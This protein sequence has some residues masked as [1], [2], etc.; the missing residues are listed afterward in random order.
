MKTQLTH[1][2]YICSMI[3]IQPIV[4]ALVVLLFAGTTQ[5]QITA[6]QLSGYDPKTSINTVTTAVP[7]LMISPD[8]RS[9]ALGDAGGALSPDA[10]SIHWNMSKLA[11]VKKKAGFAVSYTPWLRA[12]VPD[13]NLA[14]LSFYTKLKGDQAISASL[15]YFS[16]GD[17]TFTDIVG[18]TIG[19]FKPNEFALDVGYARKFSDRWSGGLT[20][21][22]IY[23]NLTGG[24]SLYDGQ[25]TKAGQS[26]AADL[27]AY[28]RNDELEVGGK[29]A[30]YST[31][32]VISN[33]GTKISYTESGR[34]DFIP[35][36][37]RWGNQFKINLDDY[38]SLAVLVDFNKLMVPTPP[39]YAVN[40]STG[41]PIKDQN[42]NY[43]IAK[44]K[45]PNRSVV[46]GILTSFAD[47]PGGFKEEIKEIN[48]S[49]GVEYWYDGQFA[50][51]AGYFHEPRTKG[52]R[53]YF[54]LG[55]GLRYSVFGLDFAYLIAT[56]QRNPLENTLR[57]TLHFDF[58][59]FKAQNKDKD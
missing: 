25:G 23:S 50:V 8:A 2:P 33:I 31:G 54:T 47:A 35:T 12:L 38:N 24:I 18:N 9:G 58:D 22:Y 51:R 26:V 36:N 29:D 44:G 41:Q 16:L 10:N 40:D 46:N 37:L 7:F 45:D 30:E 48:Y 11:F 43:V 15:R 42:G 3:R 53:Q 14:Y 6:G 34:R 20:M 28:Y 5:A 52:N 55:A 56:Q 4:I 17:I 1:L 13:I 32:I 27:S 57:F 49:V 21:R 39:I 59:S 19:Q